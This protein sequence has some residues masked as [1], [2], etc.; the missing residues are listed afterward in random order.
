MKC[1]RTGPR[2]RAQATLSF[3]CLAAAATL[4][5]SCRAQAVSGFTW[6]DSAGVSLLFHQKARW[7]TGEE[8]RFS[9]NRSSNTYALEN[10]VLAKP[11]TALTLRLHRNDAEGPS[12]SRAGLTVSPRQDGS[13]PSQSASFPLLAENIAFVLPFAT[14]SRVSS[15][16][17]VAEGASVEF[18]VESI[19]S[20][21]TFRGIDAGGSELRVSAGFTLVKAGDG[22]E[23][24]S[25]E[26][27]FAGL[28]GDEA[29]RAGLLID[30]GPSPPGAAM[31]LDAIGEGGR[32][33]SFSILSRPEGARTVIDAGILSPD[34][35][36]IRLRVP[37][38]VAIKAFFAEALGTED[39][40]LAD[41]GRLLLSKAPIGD[42]ALYRWDLLPSVLV[43]DFKDYETQDRYLK[44]LAFFAEKLGFRGRLAK[45]EEIASLHGWNAHDYRP[46]DLADFF[47][48][49]EHKS[50]PLDAEERELEGI[51]VSSGVLVKSAGAIGPGKGALISISRESSSAL[52]WTL[53]VHES[54]HA[55]FFSDPEYRGFARSLWASLGAREK[56]FWKTYFGWAGYDIGSDYLMGNEFQAYLVQQP[57]A[58]AEEY[59]T[60][61]KSAE[62]L[63]K[64]PELK[65]QVDT[66]M[67]EFGPSF[68]R[69]ARQLEAWLKGK[70]GIEAGRTVFLTPIAST[71]LR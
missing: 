51:L 26:M 44:R 12:Q 42:Y 68:A 22:Y 70:Y 49:V 45:D 31:R 71:T 33:R 10:A 29:A 28:S 39:F 8:G 55:I 20:G 47:R 35:T 19:G 38:G 57:V 32:I 3:V 6:R 43:F 16:S 17:L 62:L 61:R 69:R 53:A 36:M 48:A 67:A 66:Y 14:S 58:A 11:G 23:D 5:I 46:E 54:T 40:K 13:S 41:L 64:H 15:V 50:F 56:W 21:P 27:P 18:S 63:E 1:A 4:V 37:E 30:Y 52:R 59:F 34:A 9:G 25:I 60:K 7:P 2:A 24:Y 65:D